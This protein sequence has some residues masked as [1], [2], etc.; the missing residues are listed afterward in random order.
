MLTTVSLTPSTD[1]TPALQSAQN[2][3][4]VYG[5]KDTHVHTHTHTR[6]SICRTL[7]ETS[8][9]MKSFGHGY[10]E[11]P[12]GTGALLVPEGGQQTNHTQRTGVTQIQPGQGS[13]VPTQ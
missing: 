11:A 13:I 1:W 8:A 2:I 7:V 4:H 9:S 3:S 10:L 5:L 6:R 12:S